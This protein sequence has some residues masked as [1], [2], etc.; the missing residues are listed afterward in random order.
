MKVLITGGTKPLGLAVAQELKDEHQ[1]Y[2]MDVEQAETDFEFIQCD[3][4]NTDDIQQAVQGMETIIHLAE[5]P[6][7][8]EVDAEE[9]E[10]QELDFAT[11]GTYYLLRAAVSEG[12]QRVIYKSSLTVFDSCP[13]DWIVTETWLPRPKA[14]TRSMAKYLGELICREFARENN[15]IAVCLRLGTVVHAEEVRGKPF[16]PMWVDIRDAA[17]AF[18]M[19]LKVGN[20]RSRFHIFHIQA[21]NPE[22]RFPVAKAK[23]SLSYQP[24]YDF[25][26]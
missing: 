13:E 1:V 11:R 9:R 15:L 14:E 6:D 10:R 18:A 8:V 20:E 23:Q 4:L 17:H 22:A 25:R 7:D 26:S 3:M 16:E 21:D 2:L 5:L 12:V 24:K 19:A